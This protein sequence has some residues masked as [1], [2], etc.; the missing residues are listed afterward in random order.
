MLVRSQLLKTINAMLAKYRRDWE[1]GVGEEVMSSQ[2]TKIEEKYNELLNSVSCDAMHDNVVSVVIVLHVRFVLQKGAWASGTTTSGSK[3]YAGN[4]L[5]QRLIKSIDD[6]RLLKSKSTSKGKG[7]ATN[8]K[9][10]TEPGIASSSSGA[11]ASS[12]SGAKPSVGNKAG[13][14]GKQQK[15]DKKVGS[16]SEE[17]DSDDNIP[18]MNRKRRLELEKEEVEMLEA[19]AKVAKAELAQALQA[20]IRAAQVE[21]AKAIARE[22]ASRQGK[23]T[24]SLPTPSPSPCANPSPSPLGNSSSSSLA[25][26]SPSGSA[27]PC[28]SQSA[29]PSS[30]PWDVR[31]PSPLENPSPSPSSNPSP[32]P[33]ANPSSNACANPLP[34]AYPPNS[35]NPSANPWANPFA[36]EDANI[37]KQRYDEEKVSSFG[38]SNCDARGDDYCSALQVKNTLLAAQQEAQMKHEADRREWDSK[39]LESQVKLSLAYVHFLVFMFPLR[40]CR[41]RRHNMRAC[42]WRDRLFY[43]SK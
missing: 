8:N 15:N 1:N 7:G 41:P 12:S 10:P 3:S 13:G 30:L 25:N 35:A 20:Q 38:V 22:E 34:N 16:S 26:T 24:P 11:I 19:R 17:S 9:K 29:N 23:V 21:R 43:L 4:K 6:A 42:R 33:L 2:W 32:Y 37:W 31:S 18:V 27:H 40:V 14:K 5:M 28:T 36:T 39:L